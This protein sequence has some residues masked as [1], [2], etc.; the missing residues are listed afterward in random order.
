[1]LGISE[2]LWQQTVYNKLAMRSNPRVWRWAVDSN[3]VPTVDRNATS[4]KNYAQ[5]TGNAVEP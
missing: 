4:I 5:Q 1:M 3:V 2:E